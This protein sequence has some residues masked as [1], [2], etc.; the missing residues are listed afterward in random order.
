MD[1][2]ADAME[3]LC[4]FFLEYKI[5]IIWSVILIGLACYHW[6]LYFHKTPPRR[7][8]PNSFDIDQYR[9]PGDLFRGTFAEIKQTLF[10]RVRGL[11][12]FV[13]LCAYL[14]IYGFY[15]TCWIILPAMVLYGVLL[16]TLC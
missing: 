4:A 11:D 12:L 2:F 9:R 1:W 10:P 5:P 14:G 3:P 16:P 8:K 7:Y 6:R 15:L 13:A